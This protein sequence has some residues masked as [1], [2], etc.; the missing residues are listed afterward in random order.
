MSE[1][2]SQ[3]GFEEKC[4]RLQGMLRSDEDDLP[5]VGIKQD[6]AAA[7]PS[8]AYSALKKMDQHQAKTG[9]KS[10]PAR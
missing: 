1:S 6:A 8:K 5:V 7:A 2:V 9:H 4:A 3:P 10:Y